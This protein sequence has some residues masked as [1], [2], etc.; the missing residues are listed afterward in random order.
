MKIRQG[1]K[2]ILAGFMAMSMILSCGVTNLTE[3]SAEEADASPLYEVHLNESENGSLHIE[4]VEEKTLS[5]QEGELVQI[6][7]HPLEGYE[8]ETVSYT[9]LTLPTTSRV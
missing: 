6:A 2:K 7:S 5:V 3:V 1:T 4:G 9:H 8:T